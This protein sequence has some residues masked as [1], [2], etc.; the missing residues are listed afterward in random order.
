MG[1]ELMVPEN[2]MLRNQR[3]KLGL[4]Q[5]DVAAKAGIK[6]EQYQKF[7][8]GDRNISS[9]TFRIVHAVLAALELDTTAFDKG[10]YALE[11]LPED[12][13]LHKMLEKI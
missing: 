4:T 13:P 11:P 6:L 1:W 10:E 2:W 5:E 9:S 3:E 7:E 8:S 12:D